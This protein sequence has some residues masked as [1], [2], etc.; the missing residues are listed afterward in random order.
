MSLAQS[1]LIA[2]IN[3]E[4]VNSGVL[5]FEQ[6]LSGDYTSLTWPE[7]NVLECKNKTNKGYGLTNI[8]KKSQITDT[9]IL[10]TR[11]LFIHIQIFLLPSLVVSL[12]NSQITART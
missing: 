9:L 4:H 10:V 7:K 11:F 3:S 12:L 5:C 1:V 8:Q 2:L 6:L